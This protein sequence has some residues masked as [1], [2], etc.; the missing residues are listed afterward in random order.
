MDTIQ[1]LI[2]T[3]PPVVP[4]LSR[5]KMNLT[6]GIEIFLNIIDMLYNF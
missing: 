6:S 4:A 3:Q 2:Q 5:L 1:D